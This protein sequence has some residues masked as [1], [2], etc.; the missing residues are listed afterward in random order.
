MTPKQ[1]LTHYKNKPRD[2]AFHI[3]YSAA[4]IYNWVERQEIPYRAQ[5]AIQAAT[6]G[7]LKAVRK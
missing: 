2:A 7:K 3:G 1:L 5:L 6:G 4:A